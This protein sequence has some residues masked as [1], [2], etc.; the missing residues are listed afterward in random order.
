MRQE[1]INAKRIVVKVG[2][3]SITGDN[4]FKLDL[5][6]DAIAA[7]V[8]RGVEVIL[9]TSG[10]IATGMPLL[11]LS[12]KPADLP[13]AQALAAV[14]QSRLIARYQ[15]SLERY[16]LIAAQVLLTHHDLADAETRAN[17]KAAMDKLVSLDKVVPIVNENDTVATAEIR[18][19]DNDS[20]AAE[21]SVLASA[22]WLILLSDIDALYNMNPSKPGA[23]AIEFV[24]YGDDLSGVELDGSSTGVGT[25]GAVTKAKAAKIATEVGVDVLLT[26]TDNVAAA[27]TGE[28]V[29]TWFEANP[30]K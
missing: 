24:V 15:H 12:S 1:L 28:Q 5:L 18:F 22:D 9:V 8:S 16:G 7:A 20:L 26:S 13:T 19:G 30:D 27:L 10:A 23:Q 2:S 14:G 3:S 4:E 21:V 17:A 25:G 6:V 29:G 11:K